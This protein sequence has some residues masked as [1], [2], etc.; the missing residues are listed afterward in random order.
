MKLKLYKP[1]KKR[2]LKLYAT[3]AESSCCNIW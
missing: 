2:I 1:K 3:N